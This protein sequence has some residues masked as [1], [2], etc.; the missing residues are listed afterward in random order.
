MNNSDER[1]SMMLSNLAVALEESSTYEQAIDKCFDTSDHWNCGLMLLGIDPDEEGHKS[2]DEN[3]AF[4]KVNEAIG[5]TGILTETGKGWI[6]QVN[7]EGF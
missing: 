1:L 5:R 2:F 6:L 4:D 3:L 7:E